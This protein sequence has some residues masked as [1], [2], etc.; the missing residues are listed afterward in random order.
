MT[1]E[2]RV[3]CNR[4]GQPFQFARVGRRPRFC[5]DACREA[6]NGGPAD[7]AVESLCLQCSV[8]FQ[9]LRKRGRRV[10]FC[11]DAC[12][13]ARLADQ[14]E[15]YTREGR[16]PRKRREFTRIC[17]ICGQPFVTIDARTRACGS[18]CGQDLAK[19][20]ASAR[21]ASDRPEL[22]FK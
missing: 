11:S 9:T 18:T 8:A 22:P 15:R 3:F 14:N 16:Y 17:V 12:R 10:R 6:W 19:R 4:C 5:S 7:G 13:L 1:A 20:N 2:L 21:R